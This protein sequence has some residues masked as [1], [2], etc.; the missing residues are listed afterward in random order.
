MGCPS[1]SKS[2]LS[3][4]VC[5]LI[6]MAADDRGLSGRQSWLENDVA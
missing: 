6:G 3:D 4:R 5:V 2:F 1:R